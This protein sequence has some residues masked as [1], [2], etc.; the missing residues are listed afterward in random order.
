MKGKFCRSVGNFCISLNL[1]SME[2]LFQVKTAPKTQTVTWGAIFD[3]AAFR[4]TAFVIRHLYTL[5]SD[6]HHQSSFHPSPT[7]QPLPLGNH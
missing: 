4:Y 6:H 1:R 5:P 7:P 2:F 3:Y